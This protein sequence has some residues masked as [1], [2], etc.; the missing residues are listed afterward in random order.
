MAFWRPIPVFSVFSED[1]LSDPSLPPSFCFPPGAPLLHPLSFVSA[2]VPLFPLPH[3]SSLHPT[4]AR[5]YLIQQGHRLERPLFCWL[6]FGGCPEDLSKPKTLLGLF[7][8]PLRSFEITCFG[9]F[10]HHCSLCK[11]CLRCG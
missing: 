2:S 4:S 7:S 8:E 6:L 10:S 3:A 5:F 9:K 1:S 11:A